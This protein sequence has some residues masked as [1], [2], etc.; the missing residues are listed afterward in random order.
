MN[1][2]LAFE[3]CEQTI[4]LKKLTEE[5]FLELGSRLVKIYDERLY[6]GQY[7]EWELFL[8]E[9]KLKPSVASRLMTIHRFFIVKHGIDKGHVLDVRNWS[10]T[11]RV[12]RI[13]KD[14]KTEEVVKLLETITP[15]TS[16]ARDVELSEAKTG[17][18][19]DECK[20]P[21]LYRIDI[22]P[23]CGYKEKIYDED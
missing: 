15:L 19:Q 10:D 2:D 8:E 23:D 6:I 18:K 3:Y 14:A 9:M 13:T 4:S 22:C 12:S 7:A 1:Q 11:Y 5:N 17:I 21:R 16:Q 20:H